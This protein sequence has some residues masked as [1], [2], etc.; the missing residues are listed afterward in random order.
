MNKNENGWGAFQNMKKENQ[1][2]KKGIIVQNENSYGERICVDKYNNFKNISSRVN[3]F[4]FP[5]SVKNDVLEKEYFKKEEKKEEKEEKKEE[6]EEKKEEKKEEINMDAWS[7]LEFNNYKIK[8]QKEID[9]ILRQ[10]LNY[11]NELENKIKNLEK[12]YNSSILI[13]TNR[14]NK[15]QKL[16]ELINEI[17]NDE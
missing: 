3:P 6:K 2:L 8:K 11:K 4:R 15:K 5:D 14:I 17:I 1:T 12:E 10:N 7:I 9:E 13:N 16:V